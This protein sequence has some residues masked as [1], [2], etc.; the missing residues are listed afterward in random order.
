VAFLL[1]LACVVAF[2]FKIMAEGHK[3]LPVDAYIIAPFILLLLS[4]AIVPFISNEWW[5][6]NYPLVSFALA[7]IVVHR[8]V[9]YKNIMVAQ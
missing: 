5:G 6:K 1:V 7:T 9:I 3:V 2:L 4:I 8:L